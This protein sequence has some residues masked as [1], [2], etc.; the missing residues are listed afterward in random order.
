MKGE[1][2][3]RLSPRGE[4]RVSGEIWLQISYD[5]RK[6]GV[7]GRKG[8]AR[9]LRLRNRLSSRSPNN[10]SPL[11][12]LTSLSSSAGERL[13]ASIRSANATPSESTP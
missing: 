5:A 1:H 3:N 7:A 4:E 2:E 12:T 10:T 13:V 11:E 6:V 9:S 8:A